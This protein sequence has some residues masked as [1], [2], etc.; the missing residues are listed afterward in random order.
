MLHE[1]HFTRPL[2][3]A[4]FRKFSICLLALL[5]LFK[6]ILKPKCFGIIHRNQHNNRIGFQRVA[7]QHVTELSA[8]LPYL[9]EKHPFNT[10]KS[11]KL[12]WS[13][14]WFHNLVQCLDRKFICKTSRLF[15]WWERKHMLKVSRRHYDSRS[16]MLQGVLFSRSKKYLATFFTHLSSMESMHGTMVTGFFFSGKAKL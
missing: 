15:V 16:C 2:A 8:L 3:R 13:I 12:C 6:L 14:H 7:E 11:L 10:L 5:L 9:G 4:E 1:C